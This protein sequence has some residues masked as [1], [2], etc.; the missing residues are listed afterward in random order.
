MLSRWKRYLLDFPSGGKCFLK[1]FQCLGALTMQ[2]SFTGKQ[3]N[4]ILDWLQGNDPPRLRVKLRSFKLLRQWLLQHSCGLVSKHHRQIVIF[5]PRLSAPFCHLLGKTN[6]MG[7][8]FSMWHLCLL[9]RWPKITNVTHKI[10]FPW[11]LFGPVDGRWC[12]LSKDRDHKLPLQA[13]TLPTEPLP[14]SK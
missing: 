11:C 3:K 8:F 9:S 4:H 6:P 5:I 14:L 13:S 7:T 1:G 2:K 12:W 10:M